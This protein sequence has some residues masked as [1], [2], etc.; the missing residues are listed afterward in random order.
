MQ[1]HNEATSKNL[2]I[3]HQYFQ[4]FISDIN[5]SRFLQNSQMPPSLNTDVVYVFRICFAISAFPEN[6]ARHDLHLIKEGPKLKSCAHSFNKPRSSRPGIDA[7]EKI[8]AI[9]FSKIPPGSN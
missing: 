1:R 3:A 4:H 6:S 2:T 5:K 8:L 9:Y 7:T